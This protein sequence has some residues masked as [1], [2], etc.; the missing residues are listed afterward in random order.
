MKFHR[1]HAACRHSKLKQSKHAKSKTTSK[2]SRA[3]TPRAKKHN[4]V[5]QSKHANIAK[6]KKKANQVRLSHGSDEYLHGRPLLREQHSVDR[7][8][9]IFGPSGV[10]FGDV[11]GGLHRGGAREAPAAI[12]ACWD[13]SLW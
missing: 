13:L 1:L 4:K 3:S 7:L 11:R 8:R 12:R 2:H 6:S 9:P 5:Q 10:R